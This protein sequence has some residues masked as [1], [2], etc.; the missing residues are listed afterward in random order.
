MATKRKP[1]AKGRRRSSPSRSRTETTAR[2]EAARVA[3]PK[4]PAELAKLV[5]IIGIGASAGGLEALEEF[6]AHVPERPGAAFVVVQHLDPTHQGML[7]E[8]LQRATSLRVVEA[9]DGTPVEPDTVYVIPPGKDMSLLHATLHLLPQA[10]ARSRVLPIDFFFR[11]LAQDQGERSIGVILSGM[12]TDGTLGLRAIKEAAG[13]TFVQSLDTA[14]FDSMPRSAIDAGMADVVAPVDQIPSRIFAYRQYAHLDAGEHSDSDKAIEKICLL[15]RDY[16]GNDFSLYKRSTVSRRIERRMGLHQLLT[17]GDYL[18][19]LRENGRELELLF[20]ELLIGVTSFFRDPADW[21]RLRQDVLVPLVASRASTG[22]I[23]AWVAGCSTGE[24]AYSL[25]IMLREALEPLRSHK[26]VAVQ[27][28]ATD[29]DREAIEVARVG[30]YPENIA[31][32]VS[33]ERL[34]RFFVH[35]DRGYRVAK[36]IRES[37][38]FAPQNVIIDPPFTKVDIVSCRN[39]MIYLSPEVQRRLIPLFHYCLNP[40][41]ALFLGTAETIGTYTSLFAPLDGKSR[42]FR[43][44]AP[45]MDTPP[46]ERHFST[47]G[48]RPLARDERD[49]VMASAKQTA[50][51]LQLHVDRLLV[52]RFAPLGVLCNEKGDIL[53]ISG[54]AGKYLEPAP[55]KATSNLFAMAREGLRRPVSAV[56]AKAVTSDRP[57]TLR[58]VRIGTNGGTQ[59]ADLTLQKLTEPKELARTVLVVIAD[60]APPPPAPR[61]G[62]SA[63]APARLTELEQELQR[64]QDEAQVIREAM[65]TSQEELKS[66]NEELQSTNEELQST[67]EELTTSKEEMQ[68]LNEELQTVN[69]ELQS[70]VEDLSRSNND[71][72]NL[73]N[74]TDIAT[75]FLDTDLRVRRFTTATSKIIKLIAADVGRPITDIASELDY[76]SLAEDAREVLRTLMYKEH[77]AEARDGRAFS[78][79]IMPYRTVENVIDGIVIT[80][81]DASAARSLALAAKEQALQLRQMAESLPHL[82]WGAKPDGAW[83]FLSRQWTEYTGVPDSEHMQWGWLDQLHPAERDRVR[84]QWRAAVRTGAQFDSEFRIRGHNSAYRWFKTRAVAIRDIEAHVLRWYGTSTDIDELKRAED[85]LSALLDAIA[86]GLIALDKDMQVITVNPAAERLLGRRAEDMVG[87]ILFETLPALAVF[88]ERL[89]HVPVAADVVL[90]QGPCHVRAQRDHADGFWLFLQTRSA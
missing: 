36:D 50:H 30:L 80:F 51:N 85:R 3:A 12:G 81:T 53:Y 34:R 43:R 44:L 76:V 66:T 7:V 1:A 67:N 41:G 84:E 37:V 20:Q 13:A 9:T 60:V 21:D 77:Q 38:I 40:G 15:L 35:E 49:D 71:M 63:R 72:K 90:A 29:L 22:V 2:P 8:I 87:R 25:A 27:I 70:K 62:K 47:F 45:T 42:I 65:Q 86:D 78:V 69:H 46:L 24:E 6:L 83:D 57:I 88:E 26:S 56:F 19:F 89:H 74:S 39:L 58:G 11:S 68:S 18:R 52:Q 33:P 61:K 32:D 10:S 28:F 64:A 55:G 17:Y 4:Q 79:R 31:A 23:R 48:R 54:R 82:V 75:L 5:P 16:S 14:K 73:L 59:Y